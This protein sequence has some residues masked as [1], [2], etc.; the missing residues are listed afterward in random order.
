MVSALVI[1]AMLD[2]RIERRRALFA[3]L[4]SVAL[5][6]ALYVLWRVSC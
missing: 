2:R 3:I 6:I 5:P 4:V 1:L